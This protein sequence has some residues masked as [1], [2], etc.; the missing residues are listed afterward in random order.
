LLLKALFELIILELGSFII[1][2]V[3]TSSAGLITFSL[4]NHNHN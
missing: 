3:L 1:V 2:L 4:D